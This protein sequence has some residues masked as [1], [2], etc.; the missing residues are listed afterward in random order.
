MNNKTPEDITQAFPQLGHAHFL[1]RFSSPVPLVP[2]T[3]FDLYATDSKEYFVLVT[4]DYIDV[5]GQRDELL[6]V[7]GSNAFK[8]Q[9]I[10][11]PFEAASET[12]DLAEIDTYEGE[13]F[14]R[15]ETSGAHVNYRYL[16]TIESKV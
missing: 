13:W 9:A 12:I 5:E 15:N 16:A 4:T 1:R 2:D 6:G 14:V 11:R 3:T 7:S 8:I 10:V